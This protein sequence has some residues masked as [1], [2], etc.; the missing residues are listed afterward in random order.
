MILRCY[1]GRRSC[2]RQG[3]W[4]FCSLRFTAKALG[5]AICSARPL[6]CW[7]TIATRAS[8]LPNLELS[9]GSRAAGRPA[10]TNAR[11]GAI[12]FARIAVPGPIPHSR[13]LCCH[14]S[15]VPH[16]PQADNVCL[17]HQLLSAR[18]WQRTA[19]GLLRLCTASCEGHPAPRRRRR[20]ANTRRRTCTREKGPAA[21]RRRFLTFSARGQGAFCGRAAR[22]RYYG[23][24]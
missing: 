3:V 16:C 21:S 4:G 5:E 18:R 2:S 11:S 24:N 19:A 23:K 10:M 13:R 20:S 7:T 1:L 8:G 15:R 6:A 12:S 14:R 9:T 22:L 17:H